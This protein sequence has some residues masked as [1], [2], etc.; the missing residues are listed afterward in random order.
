MKIIVYSKP[1]CMQC[2]YTH[3]ALQKL[4]LIYQDI[5]VMKD[6]DAAR[7]AARLGHRTLP[8]VV[9]SY[10]HGGGSEHWAGFRPDRLNALG[11]SHVVRS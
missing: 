8:V 2:K 7:D 1:G 4:G 6:Q 9:V 11:A 3:L 5:D 10:A